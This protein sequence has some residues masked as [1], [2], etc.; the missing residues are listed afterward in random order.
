MSWSREGK[1]L[2]DGNFTTTLYFEPALKR[3]M[4]YFS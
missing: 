4:R 1:R 3:R 2:V